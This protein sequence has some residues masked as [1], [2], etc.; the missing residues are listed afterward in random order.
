MSIEKFLAPTTLEETLVAL[1]AYGSDALILAGGTLVMPLINEALTSPKVVISLHHA[2]LDGIRL[3]GKVEIGA[4]ITFTQLL[5]IQEIPLI[6]AAA[7]GIGSWAIRNLATVAGNLFAPPPAGDAAVG[8]L[9]LDAQVVAASKQGERRIPLDQFFTGFAQTVLEP[10]ELV[11]G[12]EF[13]TPQGKTAWLKYARREANAPAVVS[14]AARIVTD[15]AGKVTDAR[16]ALGAA[17]DF[18]MR[19]KNAEAALVGNP[20]DSESIAAASAAAMEESKPFSDAIA[21]AWY[22]KKMVGTYVGRALR[23][24]AASR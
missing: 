21:G 22:R 18:P 6:S 12:M 19:A 23:Q 13:P 1:D 8:L 15:A 14:V 10:N 4:T 9:A 5:Q 17:N 24:A 2:G 3:N 16:I 7:R 11:L 20:L